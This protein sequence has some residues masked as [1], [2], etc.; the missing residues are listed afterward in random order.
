MGSNHTIWLSCYGD[1][2]RGAGAGF[3][4]HEE[5]TGLASMPFTRAAPVRSSG[6]REASGSLCC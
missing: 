2:M 1:M 3:T 4:H 6:L 5:W